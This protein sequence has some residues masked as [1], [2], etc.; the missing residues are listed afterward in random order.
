[1]N[2]AKLKR[3]WAEIELSAL[4]F[5]YHQIRKHIGENKK[6]LGV[7]KANAYGHCAVQVAMRLESLGA[8]Y[9]A[10]ATYDEARKL[11]CNGIQLPIL[12][13][14]HTPV[15]LTSYLISY[16]ITQ[17]VSN[18]EKARAYSA[19][20]TRSGKSLKI[21]IK[22]D[23]GMSRLGFRVRGDFFSKTIDDIQHT[24]DLPNLYPEGIFT[25][26]SVSD[27]SDSGS[28]EYTFSQFD[29]FLKTINA[30]AERG[31]VFEIRHCANSGAIVN[32]PAMHLDM[33]RAGIILYGAGEDAEKLGLRSVM[34]LKS[35]IY[36][37]GEFG[38]G[39]EIGYGRTFCTECDSRIGVI[40]I[41]YADGLS[42]ALSNKLSVWTP[43]GTAAICGNICMDMSMV[44]LSDVCNV[45][46]GDEVEIFGVHQKVGLVAKMAG[47]IPYELLCAIS[48]RVPRIIIEAYNEHKNI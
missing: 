2:E 29:C 25:H 33:V 37:I 18:Y 4:E 11:R 10:V 16:N 47:T 31:R 3:N 9:L 5:N 21:H 7:V 30:L 26:F 46:E 20:A 23:T 32:Y 44:D 1:M 38:P 35:C 27:E 22:V 19:E 28:V 36:N 24:C 14:G 40:P 6:F 48:K 13:L 43:H 15:E 12:I 39:T 34:S 45:C 8:D 42:R 41:G 17:S